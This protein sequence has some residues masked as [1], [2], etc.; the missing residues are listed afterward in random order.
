MTG[1]ELFMATLKAFFE[2]K[3]S[4]VRIHE[5]HDWEGDQKGFETFKRECETWLADQKV[6]N[7]ERSISLI[8]GYMKG[9]AAQWYT[10]NQ[11]ARELAK[12]HGVSKRTFWKEVKE[13]FGD[14]NPNFTA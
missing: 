9:S 6:K 1:N 12:N 2:Q 7:P 14:I 13:R 4:K 10:M 11:K 5:L 8:M 3:E